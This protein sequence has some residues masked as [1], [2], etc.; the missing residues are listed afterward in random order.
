MSP[1]LLVL[2]LAPPLL[3]LVYA[4]LEHKRFFD[5]VTGRRLAVEALERLKSAKG[6]PTSWIYD[7]DQDRKYFAALEKQISR[8]TKS[9]KIRHVLSDGIKPS[10]ITVGGEPVSLRGVPNNWEIG[11]QRVYLPRHPVMYLFGVT[12]DGGEG[13]G[14]RVCSLGELDKW[15]SDEKENRKFVLGA[16]ALG[17]ISI[18]FVVLRLSSAS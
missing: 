1:E 17:L 13:K 4:I 8:K 5:W 10:C 9:E 11:D 14:D 7:D 3:T 18:T 2:F 6:F 16:V 12:R 15:L